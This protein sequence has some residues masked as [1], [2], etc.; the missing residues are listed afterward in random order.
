MQIFYSGCWRP[1]FTH[2]IICWYWSFTI[3]SPL[4][5][6]TFIQTLSTCTCYLGA[7]LW[8]SSPGMRVKWTIKGIGYLQQLDPRNAHKHTPSK[9]SC[10]TTRAGGPCVQFD[11][12][13]TLLSKGELAQW[14]RRGWD[15]KDHCKWLSARKELR[16]LALFLGPK[17]KREQWEANEGV[18][19]RRKQKRELH[20]VH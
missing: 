14:G 11:P 3:R 2:A 13:S 5:S 6:L 8:P 1:L 17:R 4:S 20:K 7:P 18:G 19:V 16:L 9:T 15:V 12:G 10:T